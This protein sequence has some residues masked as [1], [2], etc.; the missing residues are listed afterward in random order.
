MADLNESINAVTWGSLQILVGFP[1]G[2]AVTPGAGV[3][4]LGMSEPG[5]GLAMNNV[6]V[7]TASGV[8]VRG[9]GVE[10]NVHPANNANPIKSMDRV[11]VFILISSFDYYIPL[12]SLQPIL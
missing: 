8:G 10:G 12:L 11:F 7:G 1:G 9:T 2:G 3:T 6:E 4:A 5:V